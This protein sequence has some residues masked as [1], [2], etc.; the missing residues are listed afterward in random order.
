[1][2][3]QT[4]SPDQPSKASKEGD[5]I[6]DVELL[7][8]MVVREGKQVNAQWAIHPQLKRDLKPEEWKEVTDLM[9]QVSGLV[10]THF[11]RMLAEA[12]PDR[13]ANA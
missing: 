9:T 13:P 8:V 7:R 12:E 6:K 4:P 1:M 3:R 5:S 11:T 10:G 2:A